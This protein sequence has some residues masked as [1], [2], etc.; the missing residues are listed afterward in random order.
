MPATQET[1][2]QTS[3]C[4]HAIF[5]GNLNNDL[6][7]LQIASLIVQ[8]TR[9]CTGLNLDTRDVKVRFSHPSDCF[10]ATVKLQTPAEQQKALADLAK[11]Q[12]LPDGLIKMGRTLRVDMFQKNPH[13]RKGGKVFVEDE[14]PNHEFF[15]EKG[16]HLGSETRIL[17]FKEM[18]YLN[19]QYLKQIVARYVCAFL[20][21][22]GGTLMFGVD[23]KGNVQ[24]TP[25][26]HKQEDDVRLA[27]DQIIKKFDPPVLPQMYN[28]SFIPVHDPTNGVNNRTSGDENVLKVIKL[29]IDSGR[30]NTL[31]ATPVGD[32]F[33][34]RDGSVQGP[35]KPREIQEWCNM[36]FDNKEKAYQD[37]IAQ[38]QHQLRQAEYDRQTR[39]DL[40][41]KKTKSAVCNIL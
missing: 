21:S 19:I 26:S 39:S 3:L 11:C 12:Q 2:A 14:Q 9:Q 34:R 5:L 41:L 18:S 20:N 38:L 8:L 6:P 31:Y 7:K 4:R 30:A 16:Q 23:D 36:N 22:S 25:M 15:F 28:I 1:M 13:R 24:G 35:L 29:N 37:E 40:S 17:E 33:I 10:T 27:I 32:V